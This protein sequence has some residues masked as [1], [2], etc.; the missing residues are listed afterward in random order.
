MV[1]TVNVGARCLA[2]AAFLFAGVATARAEWRRIDSPNFTVVGDVSA[3]DL[4]EITRRFENFRDVLGRVLTSKMTATAVPTVVIVFPSDNAFTPF[5]PKFNGK[6]IQLSGLFLPRRDAN[7]IALVRDWDEGA[8]RVV[9]HEYAHLL[10]SNL[11]ETLPVW[12]NEGLA[13]FYSTFQM[14]GDREALLGRPVPGH[15]EQLN[16]RT[17]LPLEDLLN[18]KHDSP[19][20]N[21]GDR[22]S[23]FY[24]QAWA[25]THMLLVGQPTGRDKLG[26]YVASL[27][28]G[29]SPSE[30]WRKA[31]AADRTDLDLQN[32]VRRSVFSAYRLKFNE[33]AGGYEGSAAPLAKADAEALLAHFLAQQQRYDEAAERLQ[34]AATLDPDNQWQRVV[35][36]LLAAARQDT[37]AAARGLSDLAI[38]ADWLLAYFAANG[39]VDL[40]RD[41]AADVKA[42]YRQPARAL[43]DSAQKTRGEIPNALAR[44]AWLE[45][46]AEGPPSPE[47][48]KAIQRART[49]AP[50]RHDYA[51]V[52]AQVLA[53]MGEFAAA[54]TVMK[55]LVTPAVPADVR[56]PARSLLQQIE[57]AQKRRA[58]RSTLNGLTTAP[59]AVAGSGTAAGAHPSQRPGMRRLGP[60]ETQ[61]E[62]TLERIEC[63]GGNAVFVIRTAQGVARLNSGLLDRVEFITY[64]NELTGT[65]T[66]GPLKEPMPVVVTQSVGPDGKTPRVVAIEFLPKIEPPFE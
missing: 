24:A 33:K 6:P 62:A 20:Y 30:A 27:D 28:A 47:V 31:F 46:S 34:R 7:Y 38:P 11:T 44:N 1:S 13:E 29:L 23:L 50:G 55:S 42:T 2:V 22:R 4:R 35:G 36:A 48:L 26:A 49:L 21:E 45:F 60:G 18:V 66:C 52:H 10:T 3:G 17:L 19:M 58:I 25:L 40:S 5:K 9:F 56:E 59:P 14:A 61:V 32:Y 54:G 51:F 39:L 41:S 15:L 12:L 8:M 43:F 16:V 65:V 53:E 37:A 57:E 63:S 64:R